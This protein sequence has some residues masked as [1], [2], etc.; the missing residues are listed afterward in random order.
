MK[1]RPRLWK[2]EM[3]RAYLEGRKT[4]TRVPMK[5]FR[6]EF[7]WGWA[8]A[9]KDRDGAPCFV[10]EG[11]NVLDLSPF[12]VPGDRL[13]IRETWYSTPKIPHPNYRAECLGYRADGYYPPGCAYRVVPS[14]HMPRWASRITLEVVRVWVERL[15]EISEQDAMAEGVETRPEQWDACYTDAFIRVWDSCYPAYPWESNP[16][17][18]ACEFK[19]V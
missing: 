9:I 12:G 18:W 14:I 19:G 1:E 6:H 11:N 3:V 8:D 4:Q 13:W 15:Q 16:Y 10:D 2:A 7:P 5:T 17:V